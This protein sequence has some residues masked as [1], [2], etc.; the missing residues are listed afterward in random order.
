MEAFKKY[1]QQFPHFTDQVFDIAL[2][3]LRTTTLTTGDY[4]LQQGRICRN[5]AFIEEGLLRLYYLNDGKEVNL[6]V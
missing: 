2:P 1:L 3:Y 6:G 5:I 4:F